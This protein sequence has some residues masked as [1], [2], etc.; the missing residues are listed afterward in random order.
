LFIFH[1]E[2]I[3]YDVKKIISKLESFKELS[4]MD[5]CRKA[6]KYRRKIEIRGTIC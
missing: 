6:E 4:F 2:G 5:K 3:A 1:P